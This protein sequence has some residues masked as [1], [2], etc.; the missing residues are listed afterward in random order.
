LVYGY[1][2]SLTNFGLCELHAKVLVAILMDNALYTKKLLAVMKA[3]MKSI[4]RKNM[5]F[6][7]AMVYATARDIFLTF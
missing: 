3:V 5:I 2:I 6:I 7:S 1:Q 4:E